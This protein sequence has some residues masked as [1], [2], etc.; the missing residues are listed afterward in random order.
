MKFD[1][2]KHLQ[3][4]TATSVDKIKDNISSHISLGYKELHELRDWRQQMPVAIV[5]GGPSLKD[6]LDLLRRYRFIMACGSVHDYLVDNGII[7]TWCMVCDPDPLV[8]LYMK[9]KHKDIK[10]LIASQC[11]QETFDYL[12]D[13]EVYIW[14][15]SG[16]DME[17][18]I[19]GKD[20]PL[21]GGGC[22]I[23]TRALFA[24]VMFGF[25]EQHLFGFDTC[26]GVEDDETIK[27]HAYGFQTPEET[28]GDVILLKLGPDSPTFKVAGYMLGQLFDFKSMLNQ[29]PDKLNIKVFGVGPIKYIME[30]GQEKAELIMNEEK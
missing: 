11:S 7:P 3:V 12:K 8:N 14:H 16:S 18:E 13:N 22:T 21:L 23:G 4:N 2:I 26:L 19:F 17:N 1:E 28:V 25:P 5:G 9:H 20:K 27:H 15:A 29:F 30:Y 6:H 10:Y 24:I